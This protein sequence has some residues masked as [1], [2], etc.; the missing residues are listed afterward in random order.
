M[1]LRLAR[2]VCGILPPLVSQKVRNLIFPISEARRRN[3]KFS[4]K[5][6]TG[7]TFTG[8]MS[9][10]HSYRMAVHGYFE[11]RNIVIAHH[12]TKK[13]SGDIIEIGANVATE[14]ISY[15]D[16]ARG[17]VHAFEPLPENIRWMELQK[18]KRDNL[19]LY[20]NAVSDKEMTVSFKMPPATSSGTGKIVT[21]ESASED[22]ILID[23]QAAPLDSFMGN[24]HDVRFV[25]I[26]TEGHEPYVLMGSREVFRKFRPAVIIEVTPSLLRRYANAEAADIFRFFDGI[27]YRCY[28]I[29]SLSLKHIPSAEMAENGSLNWLCVPAEK[30]GTIGKLQTKI[31]IRATIPGFLLPKLN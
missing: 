8:D 30:V 7:S 2:I 26:D 24:F 9:D 27:D 21:S 10:Y 1:R 5:S 6:F 23:V 17:T 31:R 12:F 3:S 14:T 28:G 20:H 15:C 4:R 16:V 29:N 13:S 11:W 19:K 18:P 22:D 25:A